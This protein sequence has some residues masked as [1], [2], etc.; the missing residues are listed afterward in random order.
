MLNK[1]YCQARYHKQNKSNLSIKFFSSD[2]EMEIAAITRSDES[3]TTVPSICVWLFT[4]IDIN[5]GFCPTQAME[6]QFKT[7]PRVE[8]HYYFYAF[9]CCFFFFFLAKMRYPDLIWRRMGL[10]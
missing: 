7:A 2:L 9:V 3:W 8:A 10:C 5:I 4:I 6:S 1:K